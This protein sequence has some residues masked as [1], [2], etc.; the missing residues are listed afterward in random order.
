MGTFFTKLTLNSKDHINRGDKTFLN[1]NIYYTDK[2][3]VMEKYR[4]IGS[5]V[6]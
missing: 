6:L 1:G 4:P 5:K 3:P 2:F